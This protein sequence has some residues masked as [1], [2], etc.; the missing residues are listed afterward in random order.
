MSMLPTGNV[1]TIPT[2]D[3]GLAFYRIRTDLDGVQYILYFS[4]NNREGCWYLS[5]YDINE[6]AL[7]EGLK[8]V[9]Y[10][11]MLDRFRY[12][13]GLPPGEMMVIS[14]TTDDTPPT[15]FDLVPETGRCGLYYF[16]G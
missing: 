6:N 15:F 11:P 8:L 14:N 10:S 7:L 2:D 13:D 9:C 16:T 3:Q 1:L 12:M 5:M 4:Y